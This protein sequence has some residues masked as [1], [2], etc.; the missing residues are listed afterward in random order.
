MATNEILDEIISMLDPE[1]VPVE[2]I[3]MARVVDSF[4]TEQIIRDP[5]ELSRMLSD[6]EARRGEVRIIL[7]AKKIKR[8][9]LERL[10][11]VY[12]EVNR[13]LR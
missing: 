5:E 13:R 4:G 2:Y 6:P 10:T 11:A 7:D 8:D 12:T 9:I 1:Y 3:I